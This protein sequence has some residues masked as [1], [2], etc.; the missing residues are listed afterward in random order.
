[1]TGRAQKRLAIAGAVAVVAVFVAANAH[2]LNAA[3]RSQPDCI[4]RA[5]A[6]PAKRAC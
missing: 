1:M 2:F 6:A 3:L 5:D 4:L